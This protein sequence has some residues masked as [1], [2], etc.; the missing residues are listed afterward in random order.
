M[1]HIYLSR[2]HSNLCL[3]HPMGRFPWDSHRND[4]LMDKPENCLSF[5]EQ[6]YL[7]LIPS[8]NHVS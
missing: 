5:A 2:S 6:I 4:I 1:G 7:F 8:S 3:S